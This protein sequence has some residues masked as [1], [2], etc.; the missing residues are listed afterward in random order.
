[1][2]NRPEGSERNRRSLIW[3]GKSARIFLFTPFNPLDG[4]GVKEKN[5]RNFF[6]QNLHHPYCTAAGTSSSLFWRASGAC[7]RDQFIPLWGPAVRS[8]SSLF[9]W[10]SGACCREKF[11]PLLAGLWG[12]LSGPV[13][14]S[15]GGPLG[16]LSGPVHPSSGGPLGPAAVTRS[17][18]IWWA[19]GY[20]C[21]DQSIHLLV[22]LLGLLPGPVH[23]SF[24]G[25]LEPA[26]GTSSSLSG[27]PGVRSSSSLFWW[28]SGA[29]CR[30]KF[31][32]LLAGL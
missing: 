16:L 18:I 29:C 6:Q 31:I 15:S 27:G 19:S 5:F 9:W 26:A 32:P 8:S 7:C 10:A 4:E 25:P 11:I 23:H 13:H 3:M 30:D 20:W 28:T 17:S 21:R 1:M 22:G 14:P 2:K 12:L 24:G